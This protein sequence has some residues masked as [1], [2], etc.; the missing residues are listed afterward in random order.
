M[1]IIACGLNHKT[2]PLSL[3]ERFSIVP[4]EMEASL[5]SL[6]QQK[7]LQEVAILSTCNRTEF[8][9]AA[10]LHQPLLDWILQRYQCA[11]D[12]VFPYLYIH[13]EVAAIKHILR[14]ATG[15]DSMVLGEPQIL[16]QMK[17]A[18]S[19][20]E[21]AGTIGPELH[22]LFQ[23]IFSVS[24]DVRSSTGIGAHPVSIAY[25]A[26]NLAKQVF[27]EIANTTVMVVGAGETTEL[28]L[29]YL[30][31]NKVQDTIVINR[32][33]EK[34]QQFADKFGGKAATFSD[35]AMHLAN[36]DIVITATSSTLPI[37]GKGTVER[38]LK[39]RKH[40][41]IFIADLAIPRDV[42]P[43][44]AE[45]E[46][47]HLYCIDDLKDIIEKSLSGR[48]AAAEEAERLIDLQ[49]EHYT[50]WLKSLDV[51]ETIRQFRSKYEG[52]RDQEITS[53]MQLL[54]QGVSSQEVCCHLARNITNKLLHSP[55]VQLRHAGYEQ[56]L[57]VLVLAK[58]LFELEE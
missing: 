17:E 44:V 34:A 4:D 56:N 32:T 47:I 58:R 12:E 1:S 50:R 51:V 36:S 8:Y 28:V 30:T 14:V 43:E 48:Q 55:T 27:S 53:A 46:N 10:E 40:R 31:E 24:K 29:R 49:V 26:V 11:Q 25:A 3:R 20:A 52:I 57:D 39:K 9:C 5:L 41:P 16:G 45:L 35:M 42:E 23:Y 22:R 13:R 33:I 7:A 54:Q 19:A 18:F 6:N 15:L 37:I 21:S 2:A 38:V